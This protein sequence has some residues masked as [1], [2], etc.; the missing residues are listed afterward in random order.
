MKQILAVDGNSLAHRAHHAYE[1]SGMTT[2]GGRP[3]WTVY[4]FLALL[5]GI[6]EKVS[7]DA[8]VVGFDDHK[9]SERKERCPEYKAQ[10][11]SKGPELYQQMDDLQALLPLLGIPVVV[12]AG[13]E[14][15][16]VVGSAARAAEEAGWRCVIATSDRDSFGLI[17]EHTTVLRLGN[18]LDSAVRL[19]PTALYE[20]Y[21]ITPEQYLEYAA[22][23]GDTSDNLPGV[24]GIG[25]KTAAKLLAAFGGLEAALAAPEEAVKVVGK[26]NAAR[27]GSPEA[28]AALD[29]NLDIMAIRRDV[30]V[31]LEAALLRMEERV[32]REVLETAELPTLVRRLSMA[33]CGQTLRAPDTSEHARVPEQRRAPAG[34]GELPTH[35]S[36]VA[37]PTEWPQT[38]F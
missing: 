1:R 7:P 11:E 31:D 16:D 15:D 25:E 37:V 34:V 8:I 35:G 36:D 22:L 20:K 14:A 4:G 26:A 23:R 2:S 21:G 9:S 13:L 12:P 17:S 32:V 10:R 3:V 33:L 29:R 19:T 38:L 5:A 24:K 28:R 18:G 30:P 27:L 6:C